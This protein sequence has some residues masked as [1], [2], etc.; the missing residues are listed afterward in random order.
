MPDSE[1]DWVQR[2][3]AGERDAY[4][5]LFR[6]HAARV[7]AVCCARLGW[8]GPLEDMVQET[9]MRAWKEF[10]NL[11]QGQACGPWLRGIALRVCADWLRRR[12][13]EERVLGPFADELDPPAPDRGSQEAETRA[14]LD[15]VDALPEIYRE[16]VTLY[17]FGERS[18][19]EIATTLGISAAAVNARLGKAR[20]LL[21]ESLA[22]DA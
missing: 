13:R 6:H 17:Y 14:L 20:S 18:H 10:A 7:G 11:R 15:A 3:R 8:R 19:A 12:G 1:A 16:T 4:A 22:R 5:E 2:A 9:F 21:R